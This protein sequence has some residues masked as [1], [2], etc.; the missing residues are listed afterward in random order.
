MKKYILTAAALLVSAISLNFILAQG[1]G[2]GLGNMF[3]TSVLRIINEMRSCFTSQNFSIQE[4]Y[5]SSTNV[6]SV[7]ISDNGSLAGP[8]NGGGNNG[9]GNNSATRADQMQSCIDNYNT[10]ARNAISA[11]VLVATPANVQ[12]RN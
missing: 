5:S 11:P 12:G 6:L 7:E 4:T 10:A 8:G 9:G 1:N 3:S 2:N